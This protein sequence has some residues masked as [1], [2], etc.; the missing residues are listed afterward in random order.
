MAFPG[1]RFLTL[2]IAVTLA[3]IIQE[4]LSPISL[5]YF[6]PYIYITILGFFGG[7]LSASIKARKKVIDIPSF[8]LIRAHT[9]LRMI[10]GAAGAFVVFVAL[11]F[12]KLNA[13]LKLMQN[14]YAFLA[15]GITAGFSEHL[16]INALEKI[17]DNLSIEFVDKVK[18]TNESHDKSIKKGQNND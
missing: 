15:I 1:I 5:L 8:R 11:G 4:L 2:L 18:K 9:F 12:F 6:H 3:E 17:S 13:A 10:I 7:G 14:P 16:F